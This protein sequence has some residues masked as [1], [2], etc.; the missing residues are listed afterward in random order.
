M[1]STFVGSSSKVQIVE[2][3]LVAW[4]CRPHVCGDTQAGFA[5]EVESGRPYAVTCAKEDGVRA[6]GGELSEIPDALRWL[7]ARECGYWNNEED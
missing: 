3:V 5:I 7:G 6:F 4:G 2:D 1:R